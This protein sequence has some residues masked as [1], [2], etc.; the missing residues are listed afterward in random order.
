MSCGTKLE[1]RFYSWSERQDLADL[2]Y[3]E[4]ES[5]LG[6]AVKRGDCLDSSEL[7]R[8]ERALKRQGQ[9]RFDYKEVHCRCSTD[10]DQDY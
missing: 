5:R 7:Y 3:R 4:G 6:D 1:G 2:L 9:S 8:A 10:E